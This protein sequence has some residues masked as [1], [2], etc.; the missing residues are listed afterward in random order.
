MRNVFR[1]P[2]AYLNR[3]RTLFL[4]TPEADISFSAALVAA[5]PSIFGTGFRTQGRILFD[6]PQYI[7]A[8]ADR[9]RTAHT[10]IAAHVAYAVIGN[11][12]AA[13]LGVG[14]FHSGFQIAVKMNFRCSQR[15]Q[16]E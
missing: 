8:A 11:S 4:L 12:V 1:R 15:R 2:V 16:C 9:M 6:L 13:V 10:D 5:A 3:D 14:S 7:I